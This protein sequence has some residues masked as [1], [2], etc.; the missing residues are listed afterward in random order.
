MNYLEKSQDI[1]DQ[2]E[3]NA[4]IQ[5]LR[6][7][8][9]I[10]TKNLPFL[11]KIPFGNPEWIDFT[12]EIILPIFKISIDE[13]DIKKQQKYFDILDKIIDGI[14]NIRYKKSKPS[15]D[16]M[17]IAQLDDY[18]K[19]AIQKRDNNNDS[20]YT[21]DLT[22]VLY[23]FVSQTIPK[24]YIENTI[25]SF[26]R[27]YKKNGILEKK[28]THDFYI[29]I[30]NKHKD[31][32]ISREKKKIKHDISKKMRITAK[33]LTTIING[34]KTRKFKQMM[35]NHDFNEIGI[36]EK[37]FKDDLENIKKSI[38]NNKRIK[39]RKIEDLEIKL[40]TIINRYLQNRA[41]DNREIYDILKIDDK[42]IASFIYKKIE[43]I[44]FKYIDRIELSDFEYSQAILENRPDDLNP[45]NFIIGDNELY[46]ENFATLLLMLDSKTIEQIIMNQYEMKEVVW[47][48]PFLNLMPELNIDTF[49]N[50]MKYYIR[51][52]NR[53]MVSGEN[54]DYRGEVLKKIEDIINYAN[55][56]SS[57]DDIVISVLESNIAE[58]L[59]EQNSSEYVNF[60]LQM[61][62]KQEC[63]IPPVSL[64]TKNCYYESGDYS[65]PE[66]LLIGKIPQTSC[67]DLL[68]YS[69]GTVTY[70][71]VLTE[72]SDDVILIRD[73]DKKLKSRIFIF[74]RGNIVEM[75]TSFNERISINVYKQI[76]EQ[77]IKKAIENND[78]IDYVFVNGESVFREI[79]TDELIICDD[80]FKTMLPHVDTNYSAILVGSKDVVNNSKEVYR[81]YGLFCRT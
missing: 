77:I 63:T 56:Y 4:I 37:Q 65:N 16:F 14:V 81:R 71:E 80:R 73:G 45:N 29:L 5:C 57:V 75:V 17:D 6:Y 35:V 30:L 62:N 47:L 25:N 69:I 58:K 21:K 60:Y 68:E 7:N 79:I 15:F 40:D 50:I 52:K 49:K 66:R 24:S 1:V 3:I 67:I 61:L 28:L 18:V 8:K 72:A 42:K 74:R 33:R 11:K 48:I 27:E 39:K 19:S 22:L 38:S 53:L 54:R 34:V 44:G 59:G 10:N 32:Y 31:C 36:T 23:N 46:M 2:D 43:T 20:S 12:L 26:Y 41:I 9:K 13:D 55:A 51:I 78:N 70:K 76:A 64:K